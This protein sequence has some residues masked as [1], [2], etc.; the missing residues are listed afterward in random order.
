VGIEE[1]VMA[2]TTELVRGVDLSRVD[3]K[4]LKKIVKAKRLAAGSTPGEL[5]LALSDHLI[6]LHKASPSELMRCDWCGGSSDATFAKCPYC[7]LSDDESTTR[8]ALENPSATAE[9]EL[10]SGSQAPV[11]R[12]HQ[13]ELVTTKDLDAAV[14]EIRRLQVDIVDN[15]WQ[16]GR[17]LDEGHEKRL[18][19]LRLDA[20]GKPKYANWA[21]WV[22][23]E[24]GIGARYALD[25][26]AISKVF[27][28]EQIR[29]VGVTKLRVL[30][31]IP[32]EAKRANL[33]ERAKSE[34]TTKEVQREARDAVQE[35]GV[36]KQ[37]GRH[38][39]GRPPRPT[40]SAITV[41]IQPGV[42]RIPLFAA[43]TTARA[44]NLSDCP[45]AIEP[46]IN[47]VVTSYALSLAEDGL[48]LRI[49]RRREE[50]A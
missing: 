41:V 45:T 44:Q 21:Q 26:A 27:T 19:T 28:R 16:L 47:A 14:A 15:H 31:R 48:S 29:E 20:A 32:D 37:P 6:K 7:G 10:H 24:L 25:L 30:A 49:E 5:V 22:T 4:S 13:A 46:A 8:L 34:L 35:T 12:V 11:E 3:A 2:T 18:Y 36:L 43:G 42:E 23:A 17:L 33:V 38:A 40:P 9:T 1:Q 50:V 39:G